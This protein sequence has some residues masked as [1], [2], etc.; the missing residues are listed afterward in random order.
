[1]SR[2]FLVDDHPVFRYG[3]RGLIESH[4]DL[5]VCGEAESKRE[6]LTM[7]SA[8]PPDVVLVDISLKGVSGIELIK[9][10]KIHHPDLPTLVLSMHDEDLY[11]ERAIR[12]G[13]NGYLMKHEAA[14]N[15]VES[16]LRVLKGELVMSRRLSETLLRRALQGKGGERPTSPLDVL[17]DRELEVFEHIGRGL[18]TREIAETLHISVKT[19]ETHKANIKQK[20]DLR[21]ATD[22]LR[23]AVSW[24]GQLD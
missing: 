15:V 11:A 23:A 21:G 5:E 18:G 4:D 10:L 24:V 14:D 6:A 17:S 20:L 16:I 19:V 3:L 7:I 22:L 12:A 13:A 9:D 8:D 2:V 1:M